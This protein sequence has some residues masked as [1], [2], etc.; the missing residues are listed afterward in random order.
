LLATAREY[1][2]GTMI[3]AAIALVGALR[4]RRQEAR[5]AGAA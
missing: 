3:L 1:G 2:V 4:A 5:A